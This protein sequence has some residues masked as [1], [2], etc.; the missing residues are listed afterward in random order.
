MTSAH[1]FFIPAVVLAGAAIG[2]VLGRKLLLAEQ[3]EQQR[4][5][6]R[7]AKRDAEANQR[8]AE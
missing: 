8:N 4:A 6:A 3:D 1:L 7:R 5:A 2:Y